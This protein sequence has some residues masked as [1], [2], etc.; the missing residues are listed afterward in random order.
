M[1]GF[2]GMRFKPC[3]TGFKRSNPA[4]DFLSITADVNVKLFQLVGDTLQPNGK[5]YERFTAFIRTL[6]AGTRDHG[7]D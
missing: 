6:Q 1:D 5:P 7:N 4:K 2:A 3:H